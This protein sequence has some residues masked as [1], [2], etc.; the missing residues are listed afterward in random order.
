M[1]SAS[2][3]THKSKRAK[4]RRLRRCKTSDLE[5][6]GRSTAVKAKAKPRAARVSPKAA[7]PEDE[8][9]EPVEAEAVAVPRKKARKVGHA[10]VSLDS[11]LCCGRLSQRQRLRPKMP[12]RE[13]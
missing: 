12:R 9:Q 7:A 1:S 13:L 11:L 10:V 3:S 2:K 8:V 5:K 4:L 6:A